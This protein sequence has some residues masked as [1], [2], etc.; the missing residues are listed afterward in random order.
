MF[1][2]TVDITTV[3]WQLARYDAERCWVEIE[4]VERGDDLPDQG[5]TLAVVYGA[6]EDNPIAHLMAAAPELLDALRAATR[7]LAHYRVWMADHAPGTDYP[8]GIDAENGGRNLI[9]R[10]CPG[11][12]LWG[13]P[14]PKES[15]S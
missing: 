11:L 1:D 8:A 13:L 15:Q 9:N 10:L 14:L 4:T 3:P 6:K 5:Y 7:T 12:D 2:A